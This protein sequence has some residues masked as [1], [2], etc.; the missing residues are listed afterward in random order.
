MEKEEKKIAY[1]QMIEGVIDRMG[2]NSAILKG[3][4]ATVIAVSQL[5]HLLKYQGYVLI[6]AVLPVLLFCFLDT[7][8]LQLESKHRLLYNK[9]RL[10]QTEL[11]FCMNV[12]H[13]KDELK[14]GKATFCQ[15][16][17]SWSIWGFYGPLVILGAAVVIIKFLG[18]QNSTVTKNTGTFFQAFT[19]DTLLAVISCAAGVIALFYWWLGLP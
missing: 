4:A 11:D 17:K 15:T 8:Y 7:M 13:S 12:M 2:N 9:V 3:F 10:E 14:K 16:L 1:L 5:Y 6:I 19:F 18:N